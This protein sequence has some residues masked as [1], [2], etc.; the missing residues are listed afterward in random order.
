MNDNLDYQRQEQSN[1]SSGHAEI[2]REVS[3][4]EHF[5]KDVHVLCTNMKVLYQLHSLFE[6]IYHVLNQAVV[7][8]THYDNQSPVVDEASQ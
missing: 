8:I 7:A 3:L 2:M 5:V 6:V 1:E 4:L